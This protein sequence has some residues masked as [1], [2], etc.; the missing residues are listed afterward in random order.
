MLSEL[1]GANTIFPNTY[2]TCQCELCEPS[3]VTPI[4]AAPTPRLPFGQHIRM[5]RI[6]HSRPVLASIH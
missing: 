6:C 2:S 3:Q 4:A 1:L 5:E